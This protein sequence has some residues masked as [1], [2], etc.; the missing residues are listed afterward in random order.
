MNAGRA[1]VA[2]VVLVMG[3]A[4]MTVAEQ[5][6][7]AAS[8]ARANLL[9]YAIGQWPGYQV[10]PHHALLAQRLE[11]VERGEIKRLVVTMPPRHGKSALTS[12]FFPAWYLGRNPERQVICASYSQELASDFGR[13]VRNWT[14][15]PI[16]RAAFPGSGLTEDSQ[17]A[18]RFHT[19]RGGVYI[20]VGRGGSATGRGAHLFVIDDP[21]KDRE[22]AESEAI[23]EHT[24][25][26]YRTVA[27]TRLM[28]NGAVVIVMTRWHDDDLAGYVLREH[29]HEGWD[30]LNLEADAPA[31]GDPLGRVEGAAL[32][33]EMYP[34]DVLA[35]LRI[36]LGS[37]DY[38]ALYRGRP[39]PREGGI[40]KASWFEQGRY[41]TA[42][43]RDLVRRIVQSWDTAQ[44]AADTNCPS[45]CTTWAETDTGYFLLHVHRERME[46]PALRRTAESL[47]ARFNPTSL[48]IEDKSSGQ[49]LVQDL[50]NGTRLPVIGVEP[51]GDKVLRAMAVSPLCE[52]GRVHLPRVATW[53]PDYEHE[54]FRFPGSATNDQVDS[55]SQA[56][57]WMSPKGAGITAISVP[58]T[59]PFAHSDPIMGMES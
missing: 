47:A 8:F 26:W 54:M 57:K 53:L 1:F 50:H 58:T 2:V 43:H 35:S 42:P 55:T 3:L 23:R 11:A 17:A 6:L 29:G 34:V 39:V 31:Q 32:W 18:H 20:A 38:G 52:A 9:C 16:H 40:F 24:K 37:Y 5:N 28:P 51:D 36:S 45:V 33:P 59:I 25:S 48:L 10:A 41:D 56:L 7:A 19:E 4:A 27:L 13:K 44:K 46:W 21:V 22:E 49:S 12:E 14:T 30:V 15:T